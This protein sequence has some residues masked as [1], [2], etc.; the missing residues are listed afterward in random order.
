MLEGGG[1]FAEKEG[2]EKKRKQK[3]GAYNNCLQHYLYYYSSLIWFYTK[4][5]YIYPAKR[6]IKK[7][8]DKMY[9]TV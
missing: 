4:D 3:V 6:L 7:T 5:I 9:A 1:P 8:E 2:G